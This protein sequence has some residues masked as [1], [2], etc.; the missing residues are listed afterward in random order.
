[1]YKRSTSPEIVCHFKKFTESLYQFTKYNYS[2]KIKEDEMGEA[3]ST[4]ELKNDS[5]LKL[6]NVKGRE[7]FGDLGV[8]K[9]VL[10]K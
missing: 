5:N 6:K 9:M 1:V 4:Q 2:E 3:C 7:Y 8:N 10:I